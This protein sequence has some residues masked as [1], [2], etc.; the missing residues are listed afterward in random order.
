MITTDE[1]LHFL[2]Q[3]I[4][5][6]IGINIVDLGLIYDVVIE[7]DYVDIK[8][9]MTTPAC[10]LYRYLTEQAELQLRRGLPTLK[11]VTIELVWEPEW[12]PMM[13]SWEAQAQLGEPSTPVK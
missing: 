12:N 1:V 2:Q 13:M 11:A 6:E 7:G 4:D 8:M 3:V 5:P 9:T 10:P